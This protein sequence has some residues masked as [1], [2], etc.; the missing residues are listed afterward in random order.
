[1]K[2]CMLVILIAVVAVVSCKKTNSSNAS[3]LFY[4]ATW[5]LPGITAAWN[6]NNI[7]TT[8]IAQG[9]SS[10]TANNPYLQVP[11]GTNLLT[12]KTGT[13][14]LVN[15]NIYSTAFSGTSFLF[16]DTSN[17][18]GSAVGI[19]Q[20][21]D[22]L[23]LTDTAEIKYRIIDLS[24]DTTATA[25]V[26]LVNGVTDSIRLDSAA[27]FIGKNPLAS[28]LQAF[29]L[30]IKYHGEA[31]TIKIKKTGTEQLYASIANYIFAVRN[32]YSII[33]SGLSTGTGST[34]FTL[35]VL[36]HLAR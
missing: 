2:Y 5:S 3:V 32:A 15:K 16:Y 35:S 13:D 20:L 12:L 33:F 24:P 8:P 19:L 30:P 18:P 36:H 21:T 7:I 31:Y 34:G 27:V 14:T 25:D 29:Q 4:N 11:A 26:W 23:T 28:S 22:D 1:M 9:Q 17:V 10:G 6:G